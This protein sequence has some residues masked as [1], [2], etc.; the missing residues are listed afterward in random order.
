MLLLTGPP[1]SGKTTAIL[2]EVRAA[3]RAGKQDFRLIVPTATMAEHLRHELAREGFVFRPRLVVTLSRFVEP[4]VEDLPQVSAAALDRLIEEATPEFPEFAGVGS[5]P[6]FRGCAARLLDELS[7]IG[8]LADAD[9]S[10]G[11]SHQAFHLFAGV[12][13]ELGRRGMALRGRS[14]LRAASRIRNAGL[15][16][17]RSVFLDGFFTLAPAELQLIEAIRRHA[18]V[19]VALPDWSGAADARAALLSMG[20]VERRS[21]RLRKQPSVTVVS[22]GTIEQEAEETARRI[23]ELAAGGGL[24][25]DIGIVVRASDPYVPVLEAALERF[26]IPARFYFAQPLARHPAVQLLSGVLDAMLTGWDHEETLGLLRTALAVRRLSVSMDRFD[27]EARLRLPGK[28]LAGLR[29]IANDVRIRNL[30]DA[31]S[32]FDA[33]RALDLPPEQWP[34][35]L[36]ELAARSPAPRVSDDVPHERALAWRS[37]FTA[38][39]AFQAAAVEA[40]GAF[41]ASTLVPFAEFWRRMKTALRLA[42]LR[43]PDSRRN[44]VHVLDVYEARQWELPVVFVCGLLETQFPL[45]HPQDPILPDAARQALRSEGLHLRTAA[46]ADLEEKFLFELAV[47]RATELLVLSYPRF[48]AKGEENLRSFLLDEF[49]LRTPAAVETARHRVRPLPRAARPAPKPAGIREFRLLE[50]LDRRHATLSPSAIEVFLECPFRFFAA[51]TMALEGPPPAPAERLDALLQG[52]IAHAVLARW[53]ENRRPL[54]EIL[55]AEF[56]AVCGRSR[57][58]SGYRTEAIRRE[59]LRDLERFVA[60]AALPGRWRSRSERRFLL[61]LDDGLSLRGRIDRLDLAPDGKTAVVID[62]KYSREES[63]RQR[64]KEHDNGRR[65]QGGLYMLAA[66]RAWNANVVAVLFAA[67][68]RDTAWRGWHLPLPDLRGLGTA[69]TPEVLCEI[70]DRSVE[71]TLEAARRIRQGVVE[72]S[73]DQH[74]NCARC[75]FRD[76]CRPAPATATLAAGGRPW[77]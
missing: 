52:S 63:L 14:L 47:T 72:G 19:A 49:L 55:D 56:R 13:K 59:M 41:P 54:A 70:R 37:H 38:I 1:G 2:N 50:W 74:A 76:I 61:A 75:D 46:D 48:N 65:V 32:R 20:L 24:F 42:D 57:V 69:V 28:G 30:L 73:P 25:R 31:W 12:E 16:G 8:L 40:A 68:R 45:Y 39:E 26:G 18:D 71:I 27:F 36:A 64:I 67:L 33:W 4:W 15:P 5:F 51:K 77:R 11:L 53:I 34:P 17:I 7:G 58:P 21:E 62:Y 66:E 44:V 6:G 9:S 43:V 23:L 35:K 29:K 3:L 22:A 10:G 60:S